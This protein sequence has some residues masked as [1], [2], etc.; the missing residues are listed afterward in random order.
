MQEAWEIK[1]KRYELTDTVVLGRVTL[2]QGIHCCYGD[3]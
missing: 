2:A 1:L 3:D